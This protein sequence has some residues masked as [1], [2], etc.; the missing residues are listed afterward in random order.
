MTAIKYTLM[1][2]GGGPISEN[3][4]EY[5]VEI[6]VCAIYLMVLVALVSQFQHAHHLLSNTELKFHCSLECETIFDI[7]STSALLLQSLLVPPLVLGPVPTLVPSL[8]LQV[9]SVCM[10]SSLLS[11]VK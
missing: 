8:L 9:L 6:H 10:S 1:K 2:P 7:P 3:K 11:A 5:K 4:F